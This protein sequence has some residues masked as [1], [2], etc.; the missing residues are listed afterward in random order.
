MKIRTR[1]LLYNTLMVLLSL[2]VL[3]AV[4]SSVIGVWGFWKWDDN[5][6]TE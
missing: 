2:I 4:G 5:S 6:G 1:I 3:L